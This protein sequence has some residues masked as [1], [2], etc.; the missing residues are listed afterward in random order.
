MTPWK[1]QS[2]V[3]RNSKFVTI[4]VMIVVETYYCGE[5]EERVFLHTQGEGFVMYNVNASS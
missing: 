2:N 4:V 1:H 3:I 5:F